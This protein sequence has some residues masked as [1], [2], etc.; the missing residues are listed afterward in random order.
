MNKLPIQKRIQIL[1]MLCEGSSMRSISRV[2]G[3]SINTVSKLL[4]DAGEACEAFHN[5]T[6]RNVKAKR[7][8]CDE[9]WSF[10][11][12]KAKNVPKDKEGQAGDLWTW[13]AI[14]SESKLI[15]SWLV[16]GRDSDTAMDFVA[17][18]KGRLANR[19]QLTTDGH[20]AY[21]EAIEGAFGDDVDYAMMVKLYGETGEGQ[22]RY[23]PAECVGI[24]KTR[25]SGKPD[26]SHVSTSHVERQN[27]TMRMSMRRF[28]RLTNGFSK[29]IE[30]HCHALALYFVWYNF[31]R[32]HKTLKMSPAMAAGVSD[33]LWSM[34]D[35]VQM[36]DIYE[37]KKQRFAYSN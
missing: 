37:I 4:E 34:E 6:V 5:E 12:S 9:I 32:M 23:S 35:L 21:L 11:Y 27:L 15:L 26:L 18:L 17:D 10:C 16:G 2:V 19:V 20:K 7:V 31:V 14:E 25:I 1:Q 29:K 3:V 22:K 24:K 30:N 13:T 36:I 28:T 33:T 8:Q